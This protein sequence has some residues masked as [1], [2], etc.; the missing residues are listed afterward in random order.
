MTYGPA[1][2]AHDAMAA[3]FFG[4]QPLRV[5]QGLRNDTIDQAELGQIQ[6]ARLDFRRDYHAYKLDGV[7]RAE[8]RDL[9]GGL[10][11]MSGLIFDVK[12]DVTAP[13]VSYPA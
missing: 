6:D 5:A 7:S 11:D 13:T 3:R 10:N 4:L 1:N 12:H 8:A 2:L 9:W